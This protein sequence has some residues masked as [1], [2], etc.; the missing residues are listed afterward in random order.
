MNAYGQVR[1]PS[2]W[3]LVKDRF[4][5]MWMGLKQGKIDNF[6][7]HSMVEYVANLENYNKNI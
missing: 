5:G 3:Q 4:R 1:N 7:D 2:G 6:G